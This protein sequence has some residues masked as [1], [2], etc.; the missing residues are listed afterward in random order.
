MQTQITLQDAVLVNFLTDATTTALAEGVWR[1][2]ADLDVPEADIQA[3]MGLN[4][5]KASIYAWG[6][7]CAGDI[8]E[9]AV[10]IQDRLGPLVRESFEATRLTAVNRL[11]GASAGE[12][13]GYRYTVRT[14]ITPGWEDELERWYDEEHLIDLAST[15][16]AIGACRFICQDTA[17]RFFALYD[18]IDPKVI[19]GEEWQV[20]RNKEWGRRV[21]PNFQDTQ[22]VMSR[23]L[24]DLGL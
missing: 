13:P 7:P 9:L 20:S 24:L 11:P 21:R 12:T 14:N 19:E 2:A 18:L 8:A 15:R 10:R 17:P 22:R 23:R 5:P 16:G 6:L 3:T 4:I 1:L